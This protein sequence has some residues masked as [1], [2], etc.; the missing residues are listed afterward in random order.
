MY[1][2]KGISFLLFPT[3]TEKNMNKEKTMVLAVVL[4][5]ISACSPAQK[6]EDDHDSQA[7]G[8]SSATEN[9]RNSLS[10]QEKADGWELLFDGQT[11]KGWHTFLKTGMEGWQVKDG[12]LF[13][14]GK[15]G[16][17]VTDKEY[18]NFELV[19]EWMIEEQGNSGIFFHVVEDPKYPRMYET[20]PE[21]QI[22]DENN[23]PQ[24]LTESQK[25]GANSD[26][27]APTK[28]V[29]NPPGEW[30]YTRILVDQGKVTHWLNGE[31]ILDFDMNSQEW[32]ERVA[33]SKFAPMDYAK[34]RKGHIGLQD[35]GG[36]VYYRN[37]KIR[38]LK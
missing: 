11:T 2:G 30:N 13:T 12:V 28:L 29:A 7:N 5:I 21:F 33:K 19:A 10:K 15:Q 26:V 24:E 18:D 14:P 38:Q 35:H 20:G 23:Y 3:L 1:N 17:I 8:T 16:D 6:T 25:T 9:Q 31:K 4:A 27:Q 34:V 36:P 37:I 32:K 22:I